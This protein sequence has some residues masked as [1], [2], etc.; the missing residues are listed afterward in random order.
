MLVC[1]HS[2]EA[3]DVNKYTPII[4]KW[5]SNVTQNFFIGSNQ[6]LKF[7]DGKHS[8]YYVCLHLLHLGN[9]WCIVFLGFNNNK[10]HAAINKILVACTCRECDSGGP[11]NIPPREWDVHY[12]KC[13]S[14]LHLVLACDRRECSFWMVIIADGK[15]V[16]VLWGFFLWSKAINLNKK[17]Y[18]SSVWSHAAKMFYV[19]YGR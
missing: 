3:S 6:K 19:C 1:I 7:S 2:Q 9:E 16:A 11:F 13:A 8:V 10:P 14:E 18:G 4:Q 5:H 12:S 15:M 17:H